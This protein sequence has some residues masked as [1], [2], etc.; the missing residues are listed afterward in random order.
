[1]KG[2]TA[3]ALA[4]GLLASG[5]AA[6]N[7]IERATPNVVGLDIARRHIPDPVK[8]DTLRR[9][10]SQTVTETLANYG[11]LYF[12]NVTVGTPAQNFALHIDTGSSDLWVNVP[13]SEICTERGDPCSISGTYDANSSSTYKYV[14]SIFSVSYVDGSGAAGDYATDTVSIGGKSITALQFGI[15][16]DSNSAEG[17]LGIG[18]TAD[19]AQADTARQK[20]YANLPQAMTNNGLIQSNAYS[21][22]LNDLEANTGS[23]LFGGVDTDKYTGSLESVPIQT[24]D[25]TY[26]EFLITLTDMSLTD[27]TTT[28]NLTTDLPTVVI[29]DSGSSLTYLP[30]D[31]TSAIYSALKVQYDQEQQLG[32]CSCSL[33]NENIT[34]DFTFT[35]AT[36]SVAIDELV[37]NANTGTSEDRENPNSEGGQSGG[38]GGEES[39]DCVFGIAPAEGETA[40]L[41][42]TFLRSAYVVYDLANNEIS[43]AQTDFNATD[44]NVKEIGTGTTSVP[45]AT[46]VANAVEA[47]VS[48]T[49]GAR[50]AVSGTGS[51]PFATATST[52]TSGA[53]FSRSVSYGGLALTAAAVV[54]AF[55]AYA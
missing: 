34:I 26:A 18:Y 32:A 24:V 9:R 5:S 37:I 3:T 11:T 22:W 16:Y 40:V 25:D 47:A 29:L 14:N 38:Q 49:G 6:L 30:N 50:I 55:A 53:V 1:M 35:S 2:L 45:G 20:S 42:D 13:N 19:E 15:G 33:A 23:I 39:L 44:S 21:L 54:A 31:L 28:Q 36:I 43:L 17:I 10:Q 46:V 48:Q 51:S 27:G 8:R 52:T 7:L 41:G 4:A 12:A